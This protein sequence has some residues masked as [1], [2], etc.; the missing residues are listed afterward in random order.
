MQPCAEH[1]VA[2]GHAVVYF[3][4]SATHLV[5]EINVST[6]DVISDVLSYIGILR[7]RIYLKLTAHA[8][9]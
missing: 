7:S 3:A 8:I 9:S 6:V 4:Q 1:W 5:Q 2:I